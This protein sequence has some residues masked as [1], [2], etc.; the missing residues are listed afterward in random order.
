VLLRSL[1][2][3]FLGISH[4]F[5]SLTSIMAPRAKVEKREI[6]GVK[7]TW[8]EFAAYYGEKKAVKQWDNA[9]AKKSTASGKACTVCGNTNHLK[10]DCK[11][12]D[13]E[14]SNCGK[15]GHLAKVCKA[16][17]GGGGAAKAAPAKGGKACTV[18]GKDNHSKADCKFKDEECRNCGKT[19]HLAKMCRAEGG[20][21]EGGAAAKKAPA[22]GKACSVCGNTNH[23]KADCKFKDKECTNCGKTGHLAKVCRAEGG[24]AEGGASGKKAAPKKEK[25]E[26]PERAPRT[27]ATEGEIPIKR[28]ARLYNCTVK[29]EEAALKLDA[30]VNAVQTK[31]RENK[32]EKSKGFIKIARTVC[33]TEW[34]YEV[35]IVWASFEDFT[36]YKASEFRKE[37]SGEFESK[38]KDIIT[39]DFS[40]GVRVYDE[41]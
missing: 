24:G 10:A 15:T 19:G 32:K 27:L 4:P 23:L 28:V 22:A 11:F 17:G 21:A 37:V 26:R 36:A 1:H 7:Y 16:A 39:G 31:L 35:S 29:D 12:K 2:T 38:I 20:G 34:K 6:D 9:D 33:K 25:K 41:L 3:V 13:K 5:A 14:C 40:T 8:E 18:C 30:L